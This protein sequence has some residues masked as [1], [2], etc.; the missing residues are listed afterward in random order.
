MGRGGGG[1]HSRQET[2]ELSYLGTEKM[3]LLCVTKFVLSF[4]LPSLS[5]FPSLPF[6]SFLHFPFASLEKGF[7]GDP[8]DWLEYGNILEDCLEEA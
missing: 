7:L 8:C 1:V 5:L 4:P 2:Q 6:S 3:E